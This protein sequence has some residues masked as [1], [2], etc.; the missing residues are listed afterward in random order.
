M[1]IEIMS[2][3]A[4]ISYHDGAHYPIS[5]VILF[6]ESENLRINESYLIYKPRIELLK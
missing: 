3:F 2:I 4:M 1:A 5:I 6:S